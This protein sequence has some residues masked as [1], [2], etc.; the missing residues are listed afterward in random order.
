MNFV[1]FLPDLKTL[2]ISVLPSVTYFVGLQVYKKFHTPLKDNKKDDIFK[3][4]KNIITSGLA[5]VC[6]IHPLYSVTGFDIDSVT[7]THVIWGILVIDTVEYIYHYFYHRVPFLFKHVHSVHHSVKIE[8]GVS[9]RN[10]DIEPFLTAPGVFLSLFFT[11]VSYYEYLII[12]SLS[13]LATIADHTN[14]HTRKFH[15]IHHHVNKQYN[16]QQPF[17]T[18]WDHIFG[19]YYKDTALKL[20]FIP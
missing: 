9:F 15:Y 8:P 13:F 16:F 14:T 20:P 1:D 7:I 18:F 12:I 5:N 2:F 17:F 4:H 6:I 10:S 19:T 3:S 11:N